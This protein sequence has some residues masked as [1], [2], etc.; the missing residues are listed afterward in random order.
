MTSETEVVDSQLALVHC[1]VKISSLTM[2]L[3]LFSLSV[4]PASDAHPVFVETKQRVS[5]VEPPGRA[6]IGVLKPQCHLNYNHDHD[7]LYCGGFLS[8]HSNVSKGR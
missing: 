6:N 8:Q 7:K 2:F 4:M 5:L 1:R 3:I